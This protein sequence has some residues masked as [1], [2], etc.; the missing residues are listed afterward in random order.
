MAGDD[1]ERVIR[2]LP[3]L[4]LRYQQQDKNTQFLAR[5]LEQQDC[6]AQVLHL[7]LPHAAGHEFWQ[8]VCAQFD[9]ASDRK[10]GYCG[11]ISQ[12]YF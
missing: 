8:Q 10:I 5:W 9:V 11:R 6:I 7:A 2:S 3:S 12:H 1:V 4:E